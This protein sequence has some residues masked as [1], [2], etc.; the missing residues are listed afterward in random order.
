MIHNNNYYVPVVDK[1]K[2]KGLLNY[3]VILE[4]LKK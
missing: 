3:S 1:G 4:N 2:L